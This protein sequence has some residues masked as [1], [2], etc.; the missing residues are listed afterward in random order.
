MVAEERKRTSGAK[1]PF[2]LREVLPCGLKPT[3]PPAKAGGLIKALRAEV[4]RATA[5][6]NAKRAEATAKAKSRFRALRF[7]MTNK[8]R[9]THFACLFQKS[10][11]YFGW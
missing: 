4:K 1:A 11:L 8:G 10:W 6:T 3:L 5:E 7:G 9:G 2:T